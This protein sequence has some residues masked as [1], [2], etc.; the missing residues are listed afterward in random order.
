MTIGK[1]AVTYRS[2]TQRSCL[3]GALTKN[4]ESR[5][6]VVLHQGLRA[7]TPFAESLR[8]S[9]AAD[10]TSPEEHTVVVGKLYA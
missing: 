7:C 2:L 8:T 1:Q 3:L 4:P 5:A 10:C 6:H 9:T